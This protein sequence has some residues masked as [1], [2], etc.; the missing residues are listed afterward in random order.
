MYQTILYD[1]KEGIATITINR[2]PQGN[3]FSAETYLEISHAMD[4]VNDD[5]SVKAAIITGAGK[6]FCAGGDVTVFQDIIDSGR[7]ILEEDVLMTGTLVKSVKQNS[8]PVIAALNGVAAGAGMGLA[9][10][11]DFLIM[12][13]SS[14][15]FTAFINMALPGDT[16]LIFTLQ[17]A[18]GTFRTTRH[19]MLNEPI[20]APLAQEYGL[21]HVV[22]SD[23]LIMSSAIELAKK[24]SKQ[25]PQALAYQKNLLSELFYPAIDDFNKLE[26]K[27]MRLSSQ[28]EDHKQSVR[29]F[30]SEKENRALSK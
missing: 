10:A 22:V 9:L 26:A 21:A 23:E 4:K 2:I 6:F 27:Y 30:L 15:L 25:S 13:E 11:C 28:G 3:A 19:I 29:T 18:I 7:N 17:A 16:A 20:D 8:K 5:P 14:K 1:V 24:L 12:G